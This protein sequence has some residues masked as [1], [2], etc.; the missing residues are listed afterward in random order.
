MKLQDLKKLNIPD[1]PGVYFF[2]KDNDILYIGKAT[3]LL[4]RVKSYFSSDIKEKRS[5]LISDM[6]LLSNKID[7][8]LIDTVLEALI[9]EAELIKKYKPKYNTKEKDNK[10]FNYVVITNE[11]IP[12]VLLVRGRNIKI[13]DNLKNIKIKEKFGPFTSSDSIKIALQ[14]IRKIFPY[15]DLKSIKSDEYNFYRQLGLTPDTKESSF[16]SSYKNNIKNIIL[17]FK[18]RKKYL[19]D[20]MEEKMLLLAR[21]QKFEEANVIKKQ[22]FAL[23]HIND[24]QMVKRGFYYDLKDND[25]NFRIEGFDISHTSGKNIVGVMTVVLNGLVDKSE[26]KKFIVKTQNKSNDTGSLYEV[27]MRR[28][29]HTEWGIPDLLVLDGGQAQLNI[30]IQ[31]LKFY[32]LKIPVVSVLKD[33]R[34]KPKDILGENKEL[35]KKYKNDI[36]LVNNE[37]HRFA[38]NF[39]KEKR[40]RE[41]KKFDIN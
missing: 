20:R 8:V 28:F 34:H 31:V 14:I 32:Q 6:V 40:Q 36:L 2:K 24:I 10:S 39:H 21:Q 7:W 37:A 26:Y 18:G 38:I 19:L 35:I 13:N 23:K 11:K 17:F 29:K 27:L 1:K 9:L 5:V 22:I 16:L 41:F 33:E 3:S 30:G 25:K 4:N 12:K 15:L